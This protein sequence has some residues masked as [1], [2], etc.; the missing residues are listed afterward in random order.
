VSV[1][2][3]VCACVYE[4][5][6]IVTYIL[7][8]SSHFFSIPCVGG[9]EVRSVKYVSQGGGSRGKCYIGS[10]EKR[11]RHRCS[12]TDMSCCYIVM[13][14]CCYVMSCYVMLCYDMSYNGRL[15]VVIK[16]L[17]LLATVAQV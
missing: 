13:I 10:L 12:G 4:C 7:Y 11:T 15:C 3:C 2:V 6:D 8:L 16:L 5:T 17:L 9:C 1:C 14:L